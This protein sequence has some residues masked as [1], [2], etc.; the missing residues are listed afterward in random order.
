M[1]DEPTKPIDHV[2]PLDDLRPHVTEKA[3]CWCDPKIEEYEEGTVVIHNA[4]DHREYVEEAEEIVN[5]G[6]E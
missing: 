1:S 5:K 2:Y 4:A 6:E 3:S